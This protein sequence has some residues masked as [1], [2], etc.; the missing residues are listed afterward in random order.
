MEAAVLAVF[1][2]R[3]DD[4]GAVFAKTPSTCGLFSSYSH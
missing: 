2:G 4:S 1:A 3:R